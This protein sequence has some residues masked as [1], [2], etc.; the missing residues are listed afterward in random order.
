MTHSDSQKGRV[1]RL[2]SATGVVNPHFGGRHTH[3]AAVKI[4][5]ALPTIVKLIDGEAGTILQLHPGPQLFEWRVVCSESGEISR[6]EQPHN[7]TLLRQQSL[8]NCILSGVVD[9]LSPRPGDLCCD[10]GV[11]STYN[12]LCN[13][14]LALAIRFLLLIVRPHSIDRISASMR[15]AT[16]D[17]RRC[18]LVAVSRSLS[19][20]LSFVLAY[21]QCPLQSLFLAALLLPLLLL[22]SSPVPLSRLLPLFT[23]LQVSSLHLLVWRPSL[24]FSTAYKS[25]VSLLAFKS[26]PLSCAVSLHTLLLTNQW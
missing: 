8:A 6:E 11:Q 1:G 14:L 5:G 24:F 4:Y 2:E 23:L 17:I 26:A 20:S 13:N 15:C 12:H 10:R 25:S 22:S 3:N 16:T 19:R 18:S 7:I 21:L 9:C